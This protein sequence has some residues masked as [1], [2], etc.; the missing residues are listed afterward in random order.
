MG[1][2]IANKQAGRG[3]AV[4]AGLAYFGM[5]FAAGFAFGSLRT[6]AIAPAIG[7]TV[8]VVLELP[9]MLAVSWFAA[10]WLAERFD[11]EA[12]PEARLAM[13]GLAFALLMVAEASL[14][15]FIFKRTL[16]QHFEIY[17]SLPVQIGLA[18]QIAFA[19]FPVLQLVGT[20]SKLGS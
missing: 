3:S 4:K 17:R 10:R 19:F 5:V 18:G 11:V 12:S 13:G 8:A 7:E 1:A 6:L 20:R 15:I 16:F 14:S 9:V 2:A